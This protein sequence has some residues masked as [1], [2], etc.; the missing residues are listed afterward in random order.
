[1]REQKVY[2]LGDVH[3]WDTPILELFK[4]VKFDYSIDKL[5]FIGDS[6]DRGP[7][8]WEVIEIFLKI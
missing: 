7:R 4:K 1:M 3:G 6:C 5:I 8:T 2:V